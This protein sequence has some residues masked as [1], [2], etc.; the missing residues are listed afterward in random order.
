MTRV[1][2]IAAAAT[3]LVVAAGVL[4]RAL[5]PPDPLLQAQ[6]DGCERNDTTL[7]TLQSPNW[8]YVNDKD[9]PASGPPPSLRFV[10]GVVQ[11]NV[12]NVH[13]S[14]GETF[15]VQ[16]GNV[17]TYTDSGLTRGQ[18]YYYKVS[19]VNAKGEGPLSNEASAVV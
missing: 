9:A 15:L 2:W 6:A 5:S 19:A 18:T 12:M 10:S 4:A 7:H 16:L 13:V 11:P 8:V 14:G 3:A 17:L 1:V